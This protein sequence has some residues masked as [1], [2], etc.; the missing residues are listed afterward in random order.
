MRVLFVTSTRVGDA[1]LS[2]GL[3]ARIIAENPNIRVTVACGPAAA[4]LFEAVPNLERVIRLD[5]MVGSLHWAYLLSQT[6]T[7]RW[8]ILVD[9]RNAPATY[10]IRSAKTYRMTRS[11]DTG[12]R[13]KTLA[14][15]IGSDDNPPSPR[16]WIDAKR[17][18]QAQALIPD[19]PP[20]IAIG[21]TA[22]WRAKQWRPQH[23]AELIQHLTAADGILPDA[24]VAVFGRDDERPMALPVI[25][26]VPKER[27]ID[28]VGRIDLLTV[29]G[30]L[31]R[32]SLYIGNDSGLMHL[33]AASGIPTLGLFG[34]S[35][36]EQYAPWG[37][38][39]DVAEASVSY[40][41]IFPENFDHKNTDTLMDSLS[42]E[43][44]EKAARALWE[45]AKS[46]AA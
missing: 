32:A 39:C 26:S 13:I 43:D 5:K 37:P 6:I 42:V 10:L 44:A 14:R 7:Q 9:L 45:R 1:I 36:V 40:D 8:D 16:I 22:N 23:F 41:E 3:L 30:C 35:P 27:L 15:V 4:D 21:P 46:V 31:E 17:K 19:G 18:K 33:A 38:L 2:T 12:H 11:R 24:R 34:P 20:V 25:E 28:L 29:Y